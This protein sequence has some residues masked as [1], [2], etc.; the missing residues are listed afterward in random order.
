MMDI[1]NDYWENSLAPGMKGAAKVCTLWRLYGFSDGIDANTTL[2][3]FVTMM[4]KAITN[5]KGDYKPKPFLDDALQVILA[6]YQKRSI[7]FMDELGWTKFGGG[8]IPFIY[9]TTYREFAKYK[10]KNKFT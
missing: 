9:L 6:P 10:P 7:K 8:K 4:N 3:E 1:V 2:D 5:Y